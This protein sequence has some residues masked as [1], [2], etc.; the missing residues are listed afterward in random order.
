MNTEMGL[1]VESE[2][3]NRAVR[4]DYAIDFDLDNAWQ[5][6]LDENDRV[7]WQSDTETR[8]S[9]PA[10]S[11]MQRLEDWFFAHLPIEAE[12]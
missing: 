4:S 12:M 8:T 3:L 10:A 9:Q 11:F 2:A 6:T 5:L 7:I 1:L